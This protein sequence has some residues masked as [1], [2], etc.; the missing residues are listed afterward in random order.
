MEKGAFL[1]WHGGSTQPLYADYGSEP[2]LLRR[3]WFWLTDRDLDKERDDYIRQWHAE[4]V[5]FFNKIGVKQAITIIGM[6][7]AYIDKRDAK[8][9]AYNKELLPKLGANI[10]FQD[11]KPAEFLEDGFKVVQVFELN[12]KELDEALELHECTLQLNGW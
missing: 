11:E 4:E 1:G 2:S 6:M 8:L 10:R 9:F 7:P 5:E 3:F 12:Q